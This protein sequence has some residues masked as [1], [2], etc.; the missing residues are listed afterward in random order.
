MLG[1]M[2]MDVDTCMNKYLEVAPIIFPK[3]GFLSGSTVGKFFHGVRG[4]ARF[5]GGPLESVVKDL[6]IEMLESG[7]DTPLES[8]EQALEIAGCRT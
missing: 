5:D 7:P 1:V 3:E 6:V 4:A 8:T 2:K